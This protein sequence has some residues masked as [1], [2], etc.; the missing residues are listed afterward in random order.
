LRGYPYIELKSIRARR[1]VQPANQ[2]WSSDVATA[3]AATDPLVTPHPQTLALHAEDKAR[4]RLRRD[5]AP[6]AIAP[7]NVDEIRRRLQRQHT[8]GAERLRQKF[9][10]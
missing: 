6:S 3:K 1:L 9:E 4:Q 5:G 2:A 10:L 7:E 8:L